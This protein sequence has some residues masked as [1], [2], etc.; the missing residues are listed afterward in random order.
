MRGKAEAL[1][2]DG[3]AI[4]HKRDFDIGG[5]IQ[6]IRHLCTC[7]EAVNIRAC[8]NLKEEMRV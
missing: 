5:T 2:R 8:A 7:K 4:H 3:R 1:N 6:M